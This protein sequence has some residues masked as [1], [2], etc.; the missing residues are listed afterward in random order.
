MRTIL[1]RL[2]KLEH[3]H[4][5]PVETEACRRAREANERLCQRI[6]KA[7]QRLKALGHESAVPEMPELTESERATL[8]ALT[9]GQRIRYHTERR[10]DWMAEISRRNATADSRDVAHHD[11]RQY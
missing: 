6:A 8:S 3:G 1:N 5:P 7:N 9:L 10:R 11:E 4:L 2:R